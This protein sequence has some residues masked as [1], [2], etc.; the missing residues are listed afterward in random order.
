MRR[1]RWM[2]ALAVTALLAAGCGGS[3]GSGSEGGEGAAED[4]G[5]LLVWTTEDLA[6]RVKTQQAILNEWG[7]STGTTVKLVAIAEDQINTVIASAEAAGDRPDVIAALSLNG[8]NQLATDD[9]LDRDA[10]AAIVAELGADTFFPRTL[11]LT[12]AEDEQLAVPSD[13]WAQ[14]LFYRKDLLSKAGV[15]EPKTFADLEAAAK[16]LNKGKMAGIVAAT[17]PAD[18]FTQ[19]TFEHVAMANGCQ[20]TNDAGDVTLNSPQCQ[21]A[22][23][24]YTNLIK[25]YSVKGN[26]DA[27][28]TRAGY[29][30]GTAG[31]T[32][33][34]S[35]MLD[36]LAGLRNDALPTCPEC[37]KDRNFLVENTGVAT[38]LQGPG[39]AEP[40]A[41]GEV[42]SWSVLQDA[43]PK[44][45]DLVT[46]MMSDGYPE[47]LGIAPEGKLP[48]RKG[49]ADN[50]EEY[51]QAWQ[52][53]QAGV[54]KKAL[55][56]SIYPAETLTAIAAVPGSFNRWGIPQG[57]G[58]LAGAVGGQFVIPQ[59][60]AS[61]LNSGVSAADAASK[62]QEQAE[63]IKTDVGG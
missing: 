24:F 32:I 58:A 12:K 42:V 8:M 21:E 11:E 57:Q 2:A 41:F 22:M 51:V 17:A 39:G 14:L 7:K 29:F 48:V 18:S 44:A 33:W 27:D 43:S 23:T 13:A 26:Q 15:A 59:A 10:A 50:P 3:G 40:A 5:T 45:Q 62:A 16:A 34:S 36:E 20:L 28:T 9:L 60:L 56:S 38:T 61:M 53:L 19:Q 46:Y 47:W 6:D 37:K 52:K 25:N 35:F 30:A 1:S 63:Q 31:M 54:D 55:L 49:N 4:D